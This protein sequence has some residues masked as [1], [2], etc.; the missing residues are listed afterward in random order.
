MKLVWMPIDSIDEWSQD[1]LSSGQGKLAS[2]SIESAPTSQI[3]PRNS[4][5]GPRVLSVIVVVPPSNQSLRRPCE[6]CSRDVFGRRL[7]KDRQYSVLGPL[8]A[9]NL[10]GHKYAART[11]CRPRTMLVATLRI[12]H[13][14][15]IAHRNFVPHSRRAGIA[16]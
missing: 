1:G 10:A 14:R 7:S 5:H 4:D 13:S 11:F 3:P 12:K 2:R 15:Q 8:G 9:C 16:Q 6:P